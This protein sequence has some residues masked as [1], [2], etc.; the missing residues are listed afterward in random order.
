MIF[1]LISKAKELFYNNKDSGLSA[2]N[3]QDAIDELNNMLG[4]SLTYRGVISEEDWKT[5]KNGIWNAQVANDTYDI[6]Q[7]SIIYK[8]V[9]HNFT[10]AFLVY[11]TGNNRS[12][13][14][15]DIVVG[16]F[17]RLV[18][19]DQLPV[20]KSKTV[21]GTTS[22]FGNTPASILN[23]N[24]VFDKCQLTKPNGNHYLAPAYFNN[25]KVFSLHNA[26]NTSR[27]ALSNTAYEG[28]I[29]YWEFSS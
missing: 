1:N 21:S 19:K 8:P 13:Y 25:Q 22:Q 23:A 11:G 10:G 5:A 18:R 15:F 27:Q 16:K 9:S 7:Y 24:Q 4:Q 6:P 2:D 28:T 3:T 26:A 20:L 14:F 12:L 29:W 17:V